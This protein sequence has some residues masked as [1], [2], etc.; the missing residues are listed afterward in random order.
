V[1]DRAVLLT[2]AALPIFLAERKRAVHA[3]PWT[4]ARDRWL[5]LA[6]ESQAPPER[7]ARIQRDPISEGAVAAARALYVSTM[8]Q[9]A[10]LAR[11]ERRWDESSRLHFE[12]AATLYRA[13]RSPRPVPADALAAHRDG[14]AAALRGIAEVAR[15]AELR[16]A[17][18]CGACA[19]DDGR[20]VRISDELRAPTLPH[21]A[22]PRGLCRCRWYLA[23]RD[24]AFVSGLLRRQV[25]PK[26]RKPASSA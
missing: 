12:L 21:E 9:A 1:G 11:R 26:G 20:T 8:E 19:D 24:R 5:A 2:E 16:A 15:S 7:V 14:L 3:G 17:T 22:C 13:A 10:R 6:T 18:C 4:R 25:R 23:D